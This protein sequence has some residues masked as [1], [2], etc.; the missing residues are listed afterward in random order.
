V[1]RLENI[2]PWDLMPETLLRIFPTY[3]SMDPLGAPL[4]IGTLLPRPLRL[5]NRFEIVGPSDGDCFCLQVESRHCGPEY[6]CQFLHLDETHIASLHFNLV[7]RAVIQ[8]QP[9]GEAA[10]HFCGV[11]PQPRSSSRRPQLRTVAETV[12]YV[13]LRSAEIG[14]IRGTSGMGRRCEAAST[15]D[16]T[17]EL[18]KLK[19]NFGSRLQLLADQLLRLSMTRQPCDVT[20]FKR[21]PALGVKISQ[22]INLALMQGAGAQKLEEMMENI[23]LSNGDRVSITDIWTLNPMPPDGFSEEELAAVDLSEADE[24]VGPNAE[25]LRE[26]IRATY[27]CESPAE[28]EK[29]LRRFIAS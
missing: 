7:Q 17:A 21:K 26:M 15:M 16:I 9:I 6:R 2:P 19:S 22:Q 4:G 25:T 24:K 27:H 23:E 5:P 18:E 13:I 28:E 11:T 29:F 14:D 20:F 3:S 1:Q 10:G 12:T 8:G